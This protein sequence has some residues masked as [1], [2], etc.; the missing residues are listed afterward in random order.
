MCGKKRKGLFAGDGVG[1][2]MPVTEDTKY[3]TR[4]DYR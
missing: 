4:H 2:G 3:C 1:G